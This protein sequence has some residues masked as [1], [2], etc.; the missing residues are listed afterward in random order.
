M[1]SRI[2]TDGFKYPFKNWQLFLMVGM[3]SLLSA[4]YSFFLLSILTIGTQ[5]VTEIISVV[6]TI[7]ISIVTTIILEGYGISIIKDTINNSNDPI[8]INPIENMKTGIKSIVV[9]IVYYIIPLIIISAI[10]IYLDLFGVIGEIMSYNAQYGA[11]YIN[12]ISP[13]LIVNLILVFIIMGIILLISTY[14]LIIAKCRLAKYDSIKSAIQ[15][16]EILNDIAKIGWVKYTIYL[17]V[18][19]ILIVVIESI[20]LIFNLGGFI[21]SLLRMF[22]IGSFITLFIPRIYGSIYKIAKKRR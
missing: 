8:F 2:I 22:I 6:I 16:K 21:G 14:F 3:L 1:L 7:I 11:N 20:G 5:S 10:S 4:G 15:I 19:G 9:N 12:H 18:L 17:I 13:V